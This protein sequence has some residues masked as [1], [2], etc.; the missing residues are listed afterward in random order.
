MR[1]LKKPFTLLLILSHLNA[2][3]LGGVSNIA[4]LLLFTLKRVIWG[5]MIKKLKI[6]FI[7]LN[8][9]TSLIAM[10]D[11]ND[12]IQRKQAQDRQQLELEKSLIEQLGLWNA[13]PDFGGNKAIILIDILQLFNQLINL[14]YT[15]ASTFDLIDKPLNINDVNKRINHI[16]RL[17]S[18]QVNL[19]IKLGK[20]PYH[21]EN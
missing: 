6:V 1:T 4:V 12:D 10:A 5:Q 17:N 8:L 21:S 18:H 7:S 14:L 11:I 15:K 19:G 20:K 16:N 2:F 9:F 13:K 3:V